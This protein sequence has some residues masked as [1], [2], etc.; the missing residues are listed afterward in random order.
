ME[1]GNSAAEVALPVDVGY[2]MFIALIHSSAHMPV[3]LKDAALANKVLF[4]HFVLDF[5]LSL[6][7]NHSSEIRELA[8]IALIEGT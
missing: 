8:V 1:E 4:L 2:S 6:A 5:E 3:V 7:V